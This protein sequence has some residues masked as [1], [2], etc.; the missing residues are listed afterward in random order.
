MRRRSVLAAAGAAALAVPVLGAAPAVATP[1]LGPASGAGSTPGGRGR[2]AIRGVDISSLPKNEDHGAVYRTA[3]GRRVDPVRLLA[4]AGVTHARLKV[5]VNPV[6]GYNT[7]A[8]IL[9]LARRLKRAGIGIWVDFHYS[10]TWADPAHQTK[11]AAWA[12]LDVAGLSRAVY[13]HTA[14]VLGA[15]RR[16]GT[17][18]QLVQIGNELNGGMLWPEG[19]WEHFDNLGAFLKA[20]LRAARDTTPRIRTILHLANGGDNGLYRW[21]FDNVTSRGVDFDIIGLSYYPFWH[22]PVE[23]AAANMADITARYGK[24]CVIAETAY[25]FT[26]E[27]E[28]DV[29]DILHDPSQLTP[30]FPATP[31]GQSAWLRE[32]ADLAAAVPDGQGLGYCYWEGAWT[33]RKGSGWDPTN[34][35]S[36]N[37]WENLALFDFEDRALPGLRTLGSYRR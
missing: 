17:P 1:G 32:V 4:G 24:P 36:G 22:G 19:D 12:G 26:L 37:A 30:G 9:P 29:N 2:L 35:S 31:D 15:L 33:Y 14:D 23:Q 6:D 5:W 34:P 13:D 20:G 16:Q 21:W 3:D 27:S 7:K 18:A 8:R 10:D 11:P 28:D 25:P